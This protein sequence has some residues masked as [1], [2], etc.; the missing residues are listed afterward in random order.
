MTTVALK[1]KT[2]IGEEINKKILQG[3]ANANE[4]LARLITKVDF[5]D[6]EKLGKNKERADKI[7]DLIAIFQS[8]D[9]DFF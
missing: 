5:D 2:N 3:L 4:C 1:G 9:L 6:P 8:D 7:T